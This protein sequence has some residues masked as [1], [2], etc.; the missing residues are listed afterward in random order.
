MT[1]KL[2]SLIYLSCFIFASIVYHQT[3]NPE[4]RE[5][6]VTNIIEQKADIVISPYTADEKRIELN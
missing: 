2:K 5:E 6:L 3:M 4:P 1:N